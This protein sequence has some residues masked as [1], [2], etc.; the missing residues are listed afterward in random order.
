MTNRFSIFASLI[1]RARFDLAW[2]CKCVSRLLLL[3]AVIELITMPLTQYLWTWDHFLHGGL[4]FETSLL[5][6]VTFLC[7]GMLRAQHGRHNLESQFA[8]EMSPQ[9]IVQRQ[10]RCEALRSRR[11][12]AHLQENI[13]SSPSAICNLPLL[14]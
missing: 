4:D 8:I 13:P 6:I 14:I 1:V 10:E 5:I 7:F 9:M 12:S 3:L 11:P 2:T